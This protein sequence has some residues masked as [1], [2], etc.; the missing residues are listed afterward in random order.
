MKHCVESHRSDPNRVVSINGL[1]LLPE[2]DKRDEPGLGMGHL[3]WRVLCMPYYEWVGGWASR[4]ERAP[5]CYPQ[6][7]F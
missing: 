1:G 6:L 5:P 7:L 4:Q 3:K 2:R